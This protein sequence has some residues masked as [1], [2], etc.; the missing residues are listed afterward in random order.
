[1]TN[2]TVFYVTLLCSKLNQKKYVETF[3]DW[4]IVK[5]LLMMFPIYTGITLINQQDVD[6]ISL[7][8]TTKRSKSFM[9]V[10]SYWEKQEKEHHIK[11]KNECKNVYVSLKIQVS[12]NAYFKA[13]KNLN[14]TI[15]SAKRKCFTD[16]LN[17][18]NQR[19]SGPLYDLVV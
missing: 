8:L 6:D 1:M 4:L 5:C 13:R 14:V 2:I 11:N 10:P 17:T 19:F 15:Q 3:V 18:K 9:N 7:A 16:N 12:I